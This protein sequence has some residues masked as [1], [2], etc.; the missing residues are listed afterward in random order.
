MKQIVLLLAVMCF[1]IT[2]SAQNRERQNPEERMQQELSMLTEKL[3]LDEKQVL[4]V[5]SLQE[6]LSKEMSTI[7]EEKLDRDDARTKMNTLRKVYTK[8]VMNVLNE[9]QKVA[10][11]TILDE[12][13][14]K[15]NEGDS[16]QRRERN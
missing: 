12:K 8:D 11:Q 10:Y 1:S 16:R 3:S 14:S 4:S 9:E 5:K 7:R 6:D 2:L 15:R 13:E